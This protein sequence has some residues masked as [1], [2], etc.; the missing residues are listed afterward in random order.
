MRL[1]LILLLL[2]GACAVQAQSTNAP[3]KMVPMTNSL[4]GQSDQSMEAQT[5]LGSLHDISLAE[6]KPN[7]VKQ[8]KFIFSGIAV[9]AVKQ[10]NPLQLINPMAPPQYGSP[11]ENIVR[12]PTTHRVGLKIFA[13][14]F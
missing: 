3:L 8:G 9:E 10:R 14:R 11:D 2:S 12:D 7:E 4:A 6:L 1:S 13:I 5:A